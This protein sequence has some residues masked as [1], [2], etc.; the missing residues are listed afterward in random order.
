MS[1]VVVLV[2]RCSRWLMVRWVRDSS[3][4][5]WSIICRLGPMPFSVFHFNPWLLTASLDALDAPHLYIVTYLRVH[6]RTQVLY[7]YNNTR[8]CDLPR[9]EEYLKSQVNFVYT[10]SSSNVDTIVY[11]KS[12]PQLKSDLN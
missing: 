3:T 9:K 12:T 2:I 1:F 10:W 4:G 6:T 5:T 8:I 7:R 11:L